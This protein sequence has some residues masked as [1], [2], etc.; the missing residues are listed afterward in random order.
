MEEAAEPP[1]GLEGADGATAEPN[2]PRG[3]VDEAG[4]DPNGP[5]FAGGTDLGA[6]LPNANEL[7]G[8]DGAG[9]LKGP[10]TAAAGAGP[11]AAPKE[12][13]NGFETDAV[14]AGIETAAG[15]NAVLVG[16]LKT[17]PGAAEL[18]SKDAANGF[19]ALV[20]FA[21]AASEAAE[22]VPIPPK[23]LL[24]AVDDVAS[25]GFNAALNPNAGPAAGAEA[26]S[27]VIPKGPELA[28]FTEGVALLAGTGAKALKGAAPEVDP[29]DGRADALVEAV[30]GTLL[31]PNGTTPGFSV[32]AS[33]G[34]EATVGAAA[35]EEDEPNNAKDGKAA[36][37]TT[38]GAGAAPKPG[39]E[40][41]L[42]VVAEVVVGAPKVNA[43]LAAAAALNVPG[44]KEVAPNP[45]KPPTGATAASSFFLSS[46]TG[47][48]GAP[49]EKLLVE[50]L[51]GG[52]SLMPAG[53]G[54]PNTIGAD[55][56]SV[57]DEMP[58]VGA[59]DFWVLPVS[60]S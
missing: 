22:V 38:T 4:A 33:F 49:N 6:A 25:A 21:T 56:A 16:G 35:G 43:G 45:A 23:G 3:L 18:V 31:P 30:V 53:D 57:D 51:L 7:A 8:K 34:K 9:A 59:V 15:A 42:A 13:A 32:E 11:G 54:A 10:P 24:G 36:L 52:L 46:T 60:S 5:E 40:L 29:N 2:G 47:A 50:V 44:A 37:V 28:G 14:T 48:V 19:A 39:L 58:K 20:G 1:N 41:S 27:D 55:D 12:E 17:S 26:G